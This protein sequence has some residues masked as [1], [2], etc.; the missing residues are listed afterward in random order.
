M[1]TFTGLSIDMLFYIYFLMGSI[2]VLTLGIVIAK[3]AKD[4]KSGFAFVL[5][6]GIGCFIWLLSWFNTASRQVFMGTFP[7]MINIISASLLL[8]CF[9]LLS[10]FIIKKYK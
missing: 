5:L 1:D 7:W 9:L 2:I 4:S 8:V 6:A 3:K 10:R